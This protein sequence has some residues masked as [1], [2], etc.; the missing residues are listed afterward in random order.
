MGTNMYTWGKDKLFQTLRIG[1]SKLSID[2]VLDDA[3]L[4][5]GWMGV[6]P[7]AWDRF[8]PGPDAVEGLSLMR[9]HLL[10]M[11]GYDAGETPIRLILRATGVPV[12][13]LDV[14]I[15]VLD[16]TTPPGG[17]YVAYEGQ[18]ADEAIYIAYNLDEDQPVGLE[19]FGDYHDQP[20]FDS[21]TVNLQEGASQIF[22]LTVTSSRDAVTW[23]LKITAG[24]GDDVKHFLV[25]EDPTKAYKT[26]PSPAPESTQPYW[27]WWGSWLGGDPY[28]QKWVVS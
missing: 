22:R 10:D 3:M 15:K 19:Q 20:Y 1:P 26:A 11:G 18:G 6:A 8:D 4:T 27:R 23:Q 21:H 2:A 25:P 5:G 28:N 14:G 12:S 16:R 9:N 24:I 13:I 7:G 17:D